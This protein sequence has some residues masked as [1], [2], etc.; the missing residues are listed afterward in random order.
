MI[1]PCDGQTVE[2]LTA[3]GVTLTTPFPVDRTSVL[4]IAIAAACLY[5][6]KP[7]GAMDWT[8]TGQQWRNDGV[9]AASRDR[10]PHWQG[11]P[12]QFKSS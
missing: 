7:L 11:G 4:I 10:G 8:L 2:Q 12:R 6:L 9:A 5:A 3:L 1:P